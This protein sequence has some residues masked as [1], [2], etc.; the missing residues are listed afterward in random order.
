MT[1]P[2]VYLAGP[3]TNPDPVENVNKTMH[4]ANRLYDSKLCVPL[5]P[6]LSMFWHLHTPRPLEDW[7]AYDI[8]LLARCDILYRLPGA[9][10]GADKEVEFAMQHGM[11]IYHLVDYLLEMLAK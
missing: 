4:V 2:L 1:L 10:T 9:S 8:E 11:P 3:Y 6:H 5:I 7:Y